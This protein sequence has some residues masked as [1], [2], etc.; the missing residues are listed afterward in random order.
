MRRQY[1]KNNL[2]EAEKKK[3]FLAVRRLGLV[4]IGTNISNFVGIS[5]DITLH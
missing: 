1:N 3:F 5:T 4:V 2:R